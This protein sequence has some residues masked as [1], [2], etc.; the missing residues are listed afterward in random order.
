MDSALLTSAQATTLSDHLRVMCP[1]EWVPC[2]STKGAGSPDAFHAACDR[3]GPTVIVVKASGHV[4]GAVVTVNWTSS[5]S[6][7][8]DRGAFLFRVDAAG[9]LDTVSIELAAGSDDSNVFDYSSMC[10]MIGRYSDLNL[11]G[12]DKVEFNAFPEY[13]NAPGAQQ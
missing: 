5:S 8:H 3:R 12:C 2:Y 13:P 7:V 10:P 9:R 1:A 4:F 11:N 6:G